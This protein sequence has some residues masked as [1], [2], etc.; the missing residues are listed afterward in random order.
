MAAIVIGAKEGGSKV[1][2]HASSIDT[3]IKV[4]ENGTTRKISF[5]PES[6]N[7]GQETMQAIDRHFSEAEAIIMGLMQ[8]PPN[9]KKEI[10][11]VKP[12]SSVKDVVD[13]YKKGEIYSKESSD[14]E[15]ASAD[16]SN[17][18][19][20]EYNT[21][22]RDGSGQG[23]RQ[24]MGGNP[25][26]RPEDYKEIGQGSVTVSGRAAEASP[27]RKIYNT[28]GNTIDSLVDKYSNAQ[29]DEQR[30]IITQAIGIYLK[31]ADDKNLKG[32]DA[33]KYVANK[34]KQDGY[35]KDSKEN[36]NSK[37]SSSQESSEKSSSKKAA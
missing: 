20:A 5:K 28:T 2:D 27:Q 12:G 25:E 6:S 3:L 21:P 26:C 34:L 24:N 10:V 33:E 36:K 13:K 15:K 8:G 16:E 29:T 9:S 37:T 14:E 18:T 19:K 17:E 4:D 30:E 11:N 7:P 35:S 22:K 31:E 1:A 23:T 32:E